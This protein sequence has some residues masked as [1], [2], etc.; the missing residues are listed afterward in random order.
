[1]SA[2]GDRLRIGKNS[3]IF[4]QRR[5]DKV[6]PRALSRGRPFLVGRPPRN[7]ELRPAERS[8]NAK[9]PEEA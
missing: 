1:M 9:C 6:L 4:G 5:Q 2:L 8:S 3:Q 7:R